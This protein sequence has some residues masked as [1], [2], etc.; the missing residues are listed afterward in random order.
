V[1]PYYGMLSDSM[2]AELSA[3]VSGVRSPEAALARLQA[4]LDHLAG[5]EAP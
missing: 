4:R 3:A 1:T 2:Q 5:D